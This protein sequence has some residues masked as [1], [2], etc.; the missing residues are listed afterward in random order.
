V[1]MASQLRLPLLR[2]QGHHR[3]SFRFNS[4]ATFNKKED[5]I[6]NARNA[7][8]SLVKEPARRQVWN[9]DLKKWVDAPL[10]TVKTAFV[11]NGTRQTWNRNLKKWESL[12]VEPVA[13]KSSTGVASSSVSSPSPS[14]RFKFSNT[15]F[16][17][18][19]VESSA[20]GSKLG[21]FPPQPSKKVDPHT[22]ASSKVL[23]GSSEKRKTYPRADN[24]VKESKNDWR[25]SPT[26]EAKKPSMMM[27]RHRKPPIAFEKSLFE[28]EAPSSSSSSSS[29]NTLFPEVDWNQE[30]RR[31]QQ[32]NNTSIRHERQWHLDQKNRKQKQKSM[33]SIRRDHK[34]KVEIP[35]TITVQ[36]L[37][38]R[39]CIKSHKL[40]RILKSLGET[41]VQEMD[42][43]S[44]DVAELAVEEMQMIPILVEGF[45]DLTRTPLP[46][47]KS[48][49][50][51]RMPI[52]SIMGHVDHG[53]TT[54]LDALRET[55][56][57]EA[58]GITQSIG[59]FQVSLLGR[60]NKNDLPRQC[61][62]TDEHALGTT[63]DN[64]DRH[65]VITFF[66]TPG[67]VRHIY[68]YMYMD[69]MLPFSGG[70]DSYMVAINLAYL[71]PS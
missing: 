2:R 66:D 4:N 33:E 22:A 57:T 19:P 5:K 35:T 43:I 14:N 63:H 40:I 42:E 50:P 71:C 48:M 29:K 49:F 37:A 6:N 44:A 31:F 7:T 30:R 61:T 3:Q 39:M 21:L 20:I 34:M 18:K 38:E 41:H 53:K 26:L 56:T 9:K 69:R 51:L 46:T 8:Q 1:C 58:G 12:V 64:Q 65:D 70:M 11:A 60:Q 67:S 54:L 23:N 55:E 32:R 15:L 27:T 25:C 16:N 62:T 13:V 47:E 24:V 10:K 52:V 36:A 68:M 17:T 28:D 45:V 59:A